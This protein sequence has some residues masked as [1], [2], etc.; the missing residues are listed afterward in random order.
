MI[1]LTAIE[2]WYARFDVVVKVP[3]LDKVIKEGG[4]ILIAMRKAISQTKDAS[5]SKI[6]PIMMASLS[7]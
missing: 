7:S 3:L 2:V 6:D 4:G 1:L 5:I